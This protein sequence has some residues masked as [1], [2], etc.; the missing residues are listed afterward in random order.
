MAEKGVGAP[1]GKVKKEPE[2]DIDDPGPPPADVGPVLPD[3]V[4]DR[5]SFKRD[6]HQH[7]K[8][9]SRGEVEPAKIESRPQEEIRVLL[10]E[11][12]G[13]KDKVKK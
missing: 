5:D 13:K 9:K 4:V 3:L 1:P 12:D 8:S 10:S 2:P 7:G 11:T 6:K